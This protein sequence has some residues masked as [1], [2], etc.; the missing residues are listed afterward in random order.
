MAVSMSVAEPGARAHDM[1]H[2]D[3][4]D[5]NMPDMDMPGMKM[6]FRHFTAEEARRIIEATK[7]A[8]E[9][10]NDTFYEISRDMMR[11]PALKPAV[12][13]AVSGLIGR[14]AGG[15]TGDPAVLSLMDTSLY[16]LAVASVVDGCDPGAD[17]TVAATFRAVFEETA[18]RLR[19]ADGGERK[20]A[21][22][23]VGRIANSYKPMARE[24]FV[25]LAPLLGD[26]SPEVR[27]IVV[28]LI[29]MIVEND[30]AL[31]G[32]AL[33]ALDR[34]LPSLMQ[35]DGNLHGLV[36]STR[37]IGANYRE[38][39]AH[40]MANLGKMLSGPGKAEAT[41]AMAYIK[42]R[43]TGARPIP[44]AAKNPARSCGH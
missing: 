6:D 39:A 24:G 32:A 14:H 27:N 40:A 36:F 21:I 34:N 42:A 11:N 33:D 44:A 22:L 23:T 29:P 37:K 43:E 20:S 5:T 25:A 7:P 4:M 12:V 18:P 26:S 2:M 38:H 35:R 28:G 1:N 41:E 15:N 9:V 8:G 17:R 13:S 3:H 31:G 19:A 30:R 16:L 10:F